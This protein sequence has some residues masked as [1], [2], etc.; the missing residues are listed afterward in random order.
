MPSARF[1]IVEKGKEFHFVFVTN[2]GDT[3][4]RAGENI[5][6]SEREHQNIRRSGGLG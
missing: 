3:R 1:F 5:R 2:S 6:V 4:Q